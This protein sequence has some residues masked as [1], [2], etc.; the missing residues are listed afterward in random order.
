MRR[1]HLHLKHITL[2]RGACVTH[3][4]H[5]V[6]QICALPPKSSRQRGRP[7]IDLIQNQLTI[8][9]TMNPESARF[10]GFSQAGRLI[11]D[12]SDLETPLTGDLAA[13]DGM[14]QIRAITPRPRGQRRPRAPM[15]TSGIENRVVMRSPPGFDDAVRA[16]QESGPAQQ[17]VEGQAR[18]LVR[19]IEKYGSNPSARSAFMRCAILQPTPFPVIAVRRLCPAR[20]SRR[21]V[22]SVRAGIRGRPTCLPSA[23]SGE[24]EVRKKVPLM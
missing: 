3:R 11:S 18:Q 6:R 1:D 16:V 14:R 9:D 20:R 2:R 17:R 12:Q 4:G 13:G 5:S 19:M 24:R 10:P 8:I 15:E 7:S 22:A 21:I 23:S